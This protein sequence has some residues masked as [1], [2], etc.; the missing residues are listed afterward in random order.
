[1]VIR[2]GVALRDVKQRDTHG[3]VP[4]QRVFVPLLQTQGLR[5]QGFYPG[6]IGKVTVDITYLFPLSG[7]SEHLKF[8]MILR[9]NRYVTRI[10]TQL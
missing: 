4:R 3:R 9:N 8:E 10:C 6:V 5:Q 1:M 7:H 2:L